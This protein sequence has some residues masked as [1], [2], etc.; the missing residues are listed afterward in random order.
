MNVIEQSRPTSTP[1]PGVAHATWVGHDE[2]VSQ[3]SMW[4][5]TLQ[6]GAAT[7]PHRHDCDE[8]V[9]CLSGWGELVVDGQTQRFGADSTVVLPRGRDHQIFNPGP[10]PL[11]ILGVFG[12]SPVATFLPDGSAIDLPWRS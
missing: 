1:I 4:R 7:P 5:Q 11:E 8:V 3:L 6:P 10:Q 12:A 9:L 2:G